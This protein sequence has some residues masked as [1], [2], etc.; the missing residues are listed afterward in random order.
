VNDIKWSKPGHITLKV[1]PKNLNGACSSAVV[2]AT[3]PTGSTKLKK[4]SSF[5][6]IAK[7]RTFT[8]TSVPSNVGIEAASGEMHRSS[9]MSG[10]DKEAAS[11][12][13]NSCSLF[14]ALKFYDEFECSKFYDHY[15][16]LFVDSHNDDLFNPHF[17]ASAKPNLIKIFYKKITKNSISSPVAFNH[18]NSLSIVHEETTVGLGGSMVAATANN[19]SSSSSSSSSTS[20]SC[21]DQSISSELTVTSHNNSSI[22]TLKRNKI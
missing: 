12:G 19:A 20:S 17:K 10:R 11:S 22:I 7:F 21:D 8:S 13:G 2:T 9:S 4:K 15:R 3:N 1:N 6:Q 14:I 18:V 5:R 16:V